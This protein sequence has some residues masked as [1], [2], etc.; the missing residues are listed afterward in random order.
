MVIKT[1]DLLKNEIPIEEESVVIT[2]DIKAG[3][4]LVDIIN[5]F[6]T[7]GAGNLVLTIKLVLCFIT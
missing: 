2:E 7:V 4:V 6:C 3:L 1:V 5:G